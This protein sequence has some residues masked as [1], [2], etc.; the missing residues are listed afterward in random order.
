MTARTPTRNA[1]ASPIS[2]H[3]LT[4]GPGRAACSSP[5]GP[6]RLACP[7]ARFE[8]H[9]LA[10]PDS[11]WLLHRILERDGLTLD[12]PRLTKD[13]LDP[14]L[15][16]LAD[17]PLS[18]ELVGPHLRTM[19]PEAIRADFGQ[20]LTNVDAGRGSGTETRSLLASLEFSRRHLS[21]AAR[22]AL[23][24]LGLFSGGVFEVI[25]LDV[26][27]IPPEEWLTIRDELQGIALLRPDYEIGI[28][29]RPFLRFHPTLSMASSDAALA[30]QPETQERLLNAYLRL[31]GAID[32]A[33]S[34]T[35]GKAALEILDREEMN[36]RK[37]TMSALAMGNP[38]AAAGLGKTLLLY[39]RRTGRVREAGPWAQRL[40]ERTKLP[41]QGI[42]EEGFTEEQAILERQYAASLMESN[43][44][45]ALDKLRALVARLR[46]TTAFDPAFQLGRTLADLGHALLQTGA[47]AEAVIVTR[48]AVERWEKLLQDAKEPANAPADSTDER[49]GRSEQTNL[50]A[51][52]GTLANA[53]GYAGH[54]EEALQIAERGLRIDEAN[55][56]VRSVAVAHLQCAEILMRARHLDLADARYELAL[57]A[58]RRVGDEELEGTILQHQGGLADDRGQLDRAIRLYVRAL[59]MF[60]AAGDTE[61]RMTSYNLLGVV[62]KKAGRIAEAR[63]W[64]QRSRDLAQELNNQRGIAAAVGNIGHLYVLEGDL[65]RGRGDEAEARRI[66]AEGREAL[67]Q[68]CAIWR[69]Q[70]DRMSEASTLSALAKLNVRLGDLAAATRDADAALSIREPLGLI[71]AAKDYQTLAEIADARGDTSARAEWEQKRDALL[72]EARRR[73]GGGAVPEGLVLVI[74]ALA[75]ACARAG[76]DGHALEPV[77]E[78]NLAQMAAAEEPFPALAAALRELAAGRIPAVPAGLPKPLHDVLDE[79]IRAIRER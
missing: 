66:Y 2:F 62:E 51:A 53:L 15:R 45:A 49:R 41:H 63:A 5:A 32:D 38:H 34:G 31:M 6:A 11:L 21:P 73:A 14:L 47:I 79:V 43:P 27:R 10:R 61:G 78:E 64:Y 16:D 30:Q 76:F 44:P 24:W 56:N 19:T 37:V 58:A 40:H 23:P 46:Q 74:E 52:L 22:A 75:F 72:A 71:E 55:N 36:W 42:G 68:S 3:D 67:E 25:L 39:L 20:L 4:T 33:L 48:E 35:M 17:H 18:L 59:A 57:A 28:S 70:K 60:E 9:G 7:R 13:K 69:S 12:D 65:A 50:S 8:L 29:G 26:S 77:A 54:F 1:A